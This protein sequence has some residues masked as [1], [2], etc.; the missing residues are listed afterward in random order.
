MRSCKIENIAK[1]AKQNGI[2]IERS[3]YRVLIAQV[4]GNQ[5]VNCGITRETREWSLN[6]SRSTFH[7]V[8]VG[9]VSPRR[10]CCCCRC[11]Q[12]HVRGSVVEINYPRCKLYDVILAWNKLVSRSLAGLD[13]RLAECERDVESSIFERRWIILV[14]ISRAC[15]A[16]VGEMPWKNRRVPYS[17]RW[18]D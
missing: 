10:D 7:A 12:G 15:Q 17:A 18:G 14:L 6:E 1:T 11:C 8:A 16:S 5:R 9:S 13:R 4:T 3:E 2:Y